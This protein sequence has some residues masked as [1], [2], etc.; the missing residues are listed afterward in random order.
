MRKWRTSRGSKSIRWRNLCLGKV[1]YTTTSRRLFVVAIA[2]SG[3]LPIMSSVPSVAEI[4]HPLLTGN[5]VGCICVVRRIA[6][7]L[8]PLKATVTLYFLNN[9]S[10]LIRHG[11]LVVIT[12]FM[13]PLNLSLLTIYNVVTLGKWLASERRKLCCWRKMLQYVVSTISCCLRMLWMFI[14]ILVFKMLK[15]Q[16]RRI[17]S[18]VRFMIVWLVYSLLLILSTYLLTPLI[19]WPQHR[20]VTPH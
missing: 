10:V 7:Q 4:L 20:R 6:V 13:F 15:Q 1:E 11:S 9:W 8:L 19:D 5:C 18:P 12:S 2:I 16:W 17:S 3:P 14:I